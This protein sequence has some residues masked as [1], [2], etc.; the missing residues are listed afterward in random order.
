MRSR[1][2]TSEPATAGARAPGVRRLLLRLGAVLLG[3]SVLVLCEVVLR[4]VAPHS[5]ARM[6]LFP[7]HGADGVPYL[8]ERVEVDRFLDGAWELFLRDRAL[9]WR[10]RPGVRLD[11]SGLSLAPG[12]AAWSVRIDAQGRRHSGVESSTVLAL[13]DS[14]VFGWGVDDLDAFPALLPQPA[15]NLGVPG[16]SSAQGL[17]VARRSLPRH[18]PDAIVLAFGANDGHFTAQPDAHWM[19]QRASVAGGLAFHL[20]GLQ[21]AIHTRNLVHEL[22]LARAVQQH[23]SGDSGPRVSPGRFADNLRAIA[24]LVP[25]ARV[26]LLD[27]CARTEY[28]EQMVALADAWGYGLVRYK[29]PTVDGCHPSVDGHR[30]IA[31]RLAEELAAGSDAGPSVR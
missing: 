19:A 29:G 20:M 17:V 13:G 3:L 9:G 18:R 6:E 30:W 4:V 15:L 10:L 8:R 1:R 28:G 21:L 22:R 5:G 24:A 2:G 7:M 23:D 26:V 11:A 25:D 27:V 12:A 14:S 31:D 16:H